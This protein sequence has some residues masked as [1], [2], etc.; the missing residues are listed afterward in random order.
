MIT[1]DQA[2]TCKHFKQIA[3]VSKATDPYTTIES[4]NTVYEHVTLSA[5]VAWRANGACKT[6]KRDATRFSLPIKHGLYSYWYITQDNAH[7][8]EL[9]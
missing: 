7:L 1:K 9:A 2:L 5:P 8:F 4:F 3:R 6:W